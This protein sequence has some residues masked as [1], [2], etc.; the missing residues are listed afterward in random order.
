MSTGNIGK[1]TNYSVVMCRELLEIVEGQPLRSE[2]KD[3]PARMT[4]ALAEMFDGYTVDIKELLSH[5]FQEEG[6]DQIVCVRDIVT[7]STCEHHFLPFRIIVHV[8]Y[9][10]KDRVV[11]VSKIERLVRAYSHRLQLQERITRQVADAIMTYLKPAGVAVVI[12]GEHLC[13]RV[14]GVKSQS[15]Q[16]VTS[17]MLGAFRDNPATRMEALSLLGLRNGG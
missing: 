7:W 6:K 9:L 17:V 2:L 8:A 1:F 10:P 3:T 4:R 11:G 13:M 14:R 12:H 5:T 16:V 15:S